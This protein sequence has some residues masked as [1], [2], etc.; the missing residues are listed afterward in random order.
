MTST[1]VRPFAFTLIN[2]SDDDALLHRDANELEA[3]GAIRITARRVIA[4]ENVPYNPAQYDTRDIGLVHERRKKAGVHCREI[5]RQTRNAANVDYLDAIEKPYCVF[6]FRYRP[7]DILQAQGIVPPPTPVA[8]P[9][10]T[11]PSR[12]SNGGQQR[13]EPPVQRTASGSGKRQ[14]EEPPSQ[15]LDIKES[16]ESDIKDTKVLQA[17]LEAIQAKLSK[18]KGKYNR[19]RVKREPSP[20]RLDVSGDVIDL[21]SD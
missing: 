13:T 2:F 12:T 6:V 19:K 9:G 7:K 11:S 5:H 17:Q 10:N 4:K 3:I 16:D 1:S 15:N 18:A 8:P 21:T 20:I 14:R